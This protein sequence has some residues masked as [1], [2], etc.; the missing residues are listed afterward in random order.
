MDDIIRDVR[1]LSGHGIGSIGI[2]PND[3]SAYPDDSFENMRHLSEEMDLGFPY[4]ID[5]TQ[6]VARAYA[7][8]CTP[9][10][11]GFDTEPSLQYRGR[12][13]EMRGLELAPGAPRELCQAMRQVAET[14]Q[15]PRDQVASMGCSIKWI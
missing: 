5:E 1:E 15:G 7:A 11:F 13:A 6:D 9:D 8:V 2:M 12:I 10:F 3:T 4:A 14:G